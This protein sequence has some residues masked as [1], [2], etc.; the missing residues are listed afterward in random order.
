[1]FDSNGV[2]FEFE[3]ANQIQI[4]R[5]HPLIPLWA[6]G[7]RNR[8]SCTLSLFP[9]LFLSPAREP[10]RTTAQPNVAKR[11]ALSPLPFTRG[12]RR[13]DPT[14]QLSPSSR[15]RLPAPARSPRPRR[16]SP[17]LATRRRNRRSLFRPHLF[18]FSPPPR[19]RTLASAASPRTA[20]LHD[21]RRNRP[22]ARASFPP[23]LGR[24]AAKP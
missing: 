16:R 3:R 12:S 13:A 11:L 15:P 6:T 5:N 19:P 21:N 18:P 7:P 9:F 14:R 2:G 4:Q 1:L 10:A 8:P 24:R 22:P 17:R 23:R 20:P